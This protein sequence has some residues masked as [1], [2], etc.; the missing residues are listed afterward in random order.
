MKIPSEIRFRVLFAV[1]DPDMHGKLAGILRS[2]GHEVTTCP[3]AASAWAAFEAQPFAMVVLDRFA[4]AM[5]GDQLCARIRSHPDGADSVILMLTASDGDGD[6][7]ISAGADDY[8]AKTS[9]Q[10]Q[11]VLRLR[12]M[13]RQVLRM[14]AMRHGTNQQHRRDQTE[15]DAPGRYVEYSARYARDMVLVSDESRRVIDC[16]A[17]TLRAFGYTREE[18][19]QLAPEHLR[20]PE[21]CP[22][23]ERDFEG[24]RRRG[25]TIYETVLRRKDG[26][27][28]PVEVSQ[29]LIE[30]DGRSFYHGI[31]RDITDRKAAEHRIEALAR[32]YQMLYRTNEAMLHADNEKTLFAEICRIVEEAG[33]LGAIVRIADGDDGPL[34]AVTF[35]EHLR[36]LVENFLVFTSITGADREA[37]SARAFAE[38]RVIVEQDRQATARNPRARTLFQAVGLR[39]AASLPLRCTGKR[40]GVI[41]FDSSELNFFTPEI[42]ELLEQMAANI[43]YALDNFERDR[44]GRNAEQALR[45]SEERF[46]SLTEMASDWFW[47]QDENFRFTSRTS[48]LGRTIDAPASAILGKTRW[49]LG[50]ERG[51]EDRIQEHRKVLE[52]H[53]PF[54]NFE[55]SVVH[56]GKPRA[57]MSVSGDPVFDSQGRFTGYRGVGRNITD[58]KMNESRLV[59]TTNDLRVAY[60]KLADTQE[61]ERRALARELHDQVGHNLTALN[62][63]LS[64]LQNEI[65]ANPDTEMAKRISG[66]LALVDDTAQRVRHVMSSL[67]PPMMD[68]YGL[69]ATLR[70]WVYESAARSGIAIE[71]TGEDAEPRLPNNV[72]L[73]LFRVAQEAMLNAIKHSGAKRITVS[74]QTRPEYVQLIVSDDGRGMNLDEGG[75]GQPSLIRATLGMLNMRERTEAVGGRLQVFAAPGEGVQVT[76]RVPR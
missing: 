22:A 28:F 38:N 51:P 54:R 70:W 25:G 63:N 4:P 2:R 47:E 52:A 21:A 7:V 50:M 61:Q 58:R 30:I 18:I 11:F 65:G 69:F 56:P 40:V 57:Y 32:L 13:E 59:E 71:L 5:T 23:I 14:Q 31:F 53:L 36:P 67:R 29:H 74:L 60:G 24:T 75:S 16:N 9:P 35:S 34:T 68:D 8:L 19:L 44:L 73:T 62:L 48:P 43:S 6:A 72:E 55:Y 76:A 27:Q 49:E 45:A 10:A 33:M 17:A 37:I 26:S 42:L 39:S 12:V 15:P 20:A 66:S 3:D 41:T 64:R 46:R 1:V